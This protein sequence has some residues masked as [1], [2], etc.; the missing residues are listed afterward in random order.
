V[1]ARCCY[2][3][4][5]EFLRAAKKSEHC[6]LPVRREETRQPSVAIR[7]DYMLNPMPERKIFLFGNVLN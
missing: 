7:A 4:V 1:R 5:G 2:G 3:G 6:P